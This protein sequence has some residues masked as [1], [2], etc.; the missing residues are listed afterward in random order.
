MT[1]AEA[2]ISM[3]NHLS[4]PELLKV[5]DYIERLF[6]KRKKPAMR[7]YTRAEII[8]HIDKSLADSKAG[9]V[10]TLDEVE[11]MTR[12]KYGL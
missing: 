6:I 8:A 4:E 2:T 11:E 3:V 5:Q 7:T 1:T 12:K 9:R 10:Y